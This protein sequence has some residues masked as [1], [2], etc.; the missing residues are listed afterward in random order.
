MLKLILDTRNSNNISVKLDDNGKIYAENSVSDTKRPESVLNLVNRVCEKAGIDA[1][2]ID[3]IKVEEGP[4]S[5]TGLKVGVSVAN[6]LSF[7]LGKKVNGK[8]LGEILEPKYE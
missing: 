8:K 3:E 4:G 6:A 5:Y 1:K 2:S 7:G